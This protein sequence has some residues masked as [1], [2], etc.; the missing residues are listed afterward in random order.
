ML[1]C[2]LATRPFAL[3]IDSLHGVSE[4]WNPWATSSTLALI[5]SE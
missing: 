5:G 1:G 2:R 4:A 3:V